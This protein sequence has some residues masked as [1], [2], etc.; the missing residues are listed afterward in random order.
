M[1]KL[2]NYLVNL[3]FFNS[4][5]QAL[6]SLDLFHTYLEQTTISHPVVR[7]LK[8]LFRTMRNTNGIVK[9]YDY[10]AQI[11][12]YFNDYRLTHQYDAE[13]CLRY[14]LEVCYPDIHNA[15]SDN[16]FDSRFND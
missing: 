1:V 5:C 12:E 14:I 16:E 3:C 2:E 10:M 9:T 13:Q 8:E 11:H 6:Y 7:T 4:T 15:A